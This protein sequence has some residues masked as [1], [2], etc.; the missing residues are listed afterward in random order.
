MNESNQPSDILDTPSL[1]EP[2]PIAPTILY[3]SL[4]SRLKAV[5]IDVLLILLIFSITSVIIGQLGSVETWIR[6]F[7][8]VF[9]LYAYEPLF[10]SFLGGTLGHMV[11]GIRVKDV[12]SNRR[13]NILQASVR[14]IVKYLLGWLSFLTL[15]SNTRK[16]AIH[17]IISGS[18]VV[19]K[20]GGT[21]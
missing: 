8:F 5:V 13:I 4:V 21:A 11:V 6:V 1:S 7:I 14:F 16:R 9:S 10:I 3:P 19:F 20:S 12:D 2:K 15:I 17:D 18:L